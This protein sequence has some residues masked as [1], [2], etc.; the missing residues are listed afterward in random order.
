MREVVAKGVLGMAM[1]A[2]GFFAGLSGAAGI[3]AGRGWLATTT[4]GFLVRGVA[5]AAR[6]MGLET[7][8]FAGA[9]TGAGFDSV[10]EVMVVVGAVMGSGAGWG[11][12]GARLLP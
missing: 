3:A 5:G 1:S 10:R 7:G 11:V 8:A 4:R 9:A 2:G 12:M 6:V